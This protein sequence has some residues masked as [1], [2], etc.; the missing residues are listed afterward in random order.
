[1]EPANQLAAL[2]LHRRLRPLPSRCLDGRRHHRAQRRAGALVGPGG[3]NAAPLFRLKQLSR[4][5]S[6]ARGLNWHRTRFPYR[7]LRPATYNIT[8][9]VSRAFHGFC[10]G[11]RR[12]A[13]AWRAKREAPTS[14]LGEGRRCTRFKS[15]RLA[16]NPP[17]VE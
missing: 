16:A 5:R 8:G 9:Q 6:S 12:W 10:A 15:V 2:W 11:S 3:Q 17:F 7:R 4:L 14:R 13:K 1:M